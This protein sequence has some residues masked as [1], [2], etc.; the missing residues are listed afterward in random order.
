MVNSSTS[1]HLL[2]HTCMKHIMLVLVVIVAVVMSPVSSAWQDV[3]MSQA[4]SQLDQAR[5]FLNNYPTERFMNEQRLRQVAEARNQGDVVSRIGYNSIQADATAIE[6]TI[7]DRLRSAREALNRGSFEQFNHEKNLL[8]V[9]QQKLA[10][11]SK[12]WDQVIGSTNSSEPPRQELNGP[13]EQQEQSLSQ[14]G[15]EVVSNAP[16]PPTSPTFLG[17][18]L[19]TPVVVTGVAVAVGTAA[20]ITNNGDDTTDTTGGNN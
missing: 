3:G 18:S 14:A 8:N 16:P 15:P 20:A 13:P 7:Q 9:Q 4:S 17:M 11:L 2:W 12:R 5:Q 6:R 19:T 1:S 10:E